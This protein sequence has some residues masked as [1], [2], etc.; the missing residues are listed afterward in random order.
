MHK[1]QFKSWLGLGITILGS[2]VMGLSL[3]LADIFHPNES[4]AAKA[5]FY[6]VCVIAFIIWFIGLMICVTYKDDSST[7]KAEGIIALICFISGYV[8]FTIGCLEKTRVLSNR[9]ILG[10]GYAL[11]LGFGL[12]VPFIIS[13]SKTWYVYYNIKALEACFPVSYKKDLKKII[14]IFRHDKHFKS[15]PINIRYTFNLNPKD[16]IK[17]PVRLYFE[18][19]KDSQWHKL[20]DTQK[21]LISCLLSRSANGYVREKY[22][23]ILIQSHQ[24]IAIPFIVYNGSDYVREIVDGIYEGLK[25]SPN[26]E[27]KY[28]CAYN[29][30]FLK[31]NYDRMLAYW[32]YYERAN[33]PFYKDYN[34]YKLF[35]ECFGMS[36]ALYKRSQKKD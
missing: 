32:A 29:H 1:K 30:A 13:K 36:R 31:S 3:I 22:T 15:I 33:T 19:I 4:D 7:V 26:K 2:L 14:H 17:L 6:A 10:G 27:I 18:D 25:D 35:T 28:Y 11:F 20:N 24:L 8:I 16:R 12:G 23:K 34:G 9:L 5:G 21:L